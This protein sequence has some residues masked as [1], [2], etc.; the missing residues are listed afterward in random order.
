MK[1]LQL[2]VSI[3]FTFAFLRK[4][5]QQWLLSNN[6]TDGSDLSFRDIFIP[7]GINSASMFEPPSLPEEDCRRILFHDDS[8]V[9][10]RRFLEN[11]EEV[12]GTFRFRGRFVNLIW[13]IKISPVIA[14]PMNILRKASLAHNGNPSDSVGAG[15]C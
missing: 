13:E 15:T 4:A 11:L 5:Q 14:V 6:H 9:I 8:N 3:S 2:V 12:A 7:S 1:S 10:Q